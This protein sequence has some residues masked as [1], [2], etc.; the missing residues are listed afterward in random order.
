MHAIPPDTWKAASPD[1]ELTGEL[2]DFAHRL[3]QAGSLLEL[4]RTYLRGIGRIVPLPM[5]GIYHLDPL[6]GTVE[7]Y[8]ATNVSDI[9][10]SRYEQVG[11]TEDPIIARV[12]EQ[13]QVGYSLAVMEPDRWLRS[14]VY[15]EV[16]SLHEMIHAAQAPVFSGGQI[17]GTL[18]FGSDQ[19]RPSLSQGE[20]ARMD[21]VARAFGLALSAVR[22]T[23]QMARRCEQAVTALDLCSTPV[24]VTSGAAEEPHL[25]P[26]AQRLLDRTTDG[27]DLLYRLLASPGPHEPSFTREIAVR[28]RDGGEGTVRAHSRASETHPGA[29]VTILEC[30]G[31]EPPLVGPRW[32]ALTPREREVAA[33]LVRGLTDRD[34]A[35]ELHL[36]RH[37][38]KQY[39]KSIY[40]KAAVRSRVELAH[41]AL[42]DHDRSAAG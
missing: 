22:R 21:F 18:A 24:A 32:A 14:T 15:R 16:F 5:H 9:F 13:G 8:A 35:D 39:V 12:M 6:T 38:V 28:W 40:R 37:T 36:S 7:R 30:D 17:V 31:A 41:L 27:R 11:R 2:L 20:L 23:E 34:M 25:N 1:S 33:L 19:Q 3:T 4:E 26:A 29:L 42:A 10:L